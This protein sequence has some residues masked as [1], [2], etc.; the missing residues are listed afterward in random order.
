MLS[1]TLENNFLVPNC[2]EDFLTTRRQELPT[3][4]SPNGAIYITTPESLRRTKTFYPKSNECKKDK[5]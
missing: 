4:Y 3:Y 5:K 2:R 1:L